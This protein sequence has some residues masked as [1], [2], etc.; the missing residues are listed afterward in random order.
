V[1]A[2]AAT[3]PRVGQLAASNQIRASEMLVEAA[4]KRRTSH[5]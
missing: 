1:T 4:L 5:P 2:A 3:A